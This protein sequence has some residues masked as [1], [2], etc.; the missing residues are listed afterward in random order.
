MRQITKCSLLAGIAVP[1]SYFAAQ[2]IAAPFFPNFS[3]LQ[4]AASV[5]GSD[6]STRPGVFNAGAAV[7]G[8]ISLFASAG[9]ILALQGRARYIGLLAGACFFSFGLAS[10]WAASFPLPDPRHDPGA[11][12]LGM[13]VAP[14][15]ALAASFVL[16]FATY[17][18]TYLVFNTVAFFAI[19]AAFSGLV[20][21]DTSNYAGLLQRIAAFIMLT[22]MAAVSFALM[23]LA[24]K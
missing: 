11:L 1:F 18:R 21:M 15:A 4:H 12:G 20:P 5:L 24:A 22:P 23:R 8:L 3:I 7:T 13:F 2:A 6:V 10:I 14:F 19:A 17:L 9:P 16:R